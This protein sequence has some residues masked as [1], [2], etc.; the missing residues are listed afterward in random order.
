MKIPLNKLIY[1]IAEGF[2]LLNKV[3]YTVN[4][5]TKIIKLLNIPITISM[6]ITI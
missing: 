5:K 6:V 3:L 2:T 4:R 1:N